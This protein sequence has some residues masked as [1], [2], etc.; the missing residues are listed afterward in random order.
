MSELAFLQD[1]CERP[2]DDAPRLIYADWLEE[3]GQ[4]GQ[5]TL[6]RLDAQIEALP[7]DDPRRRQLELDRDELRTELLGEACV[8]GE[9]PGPSW[10]ELWSR[11]RASCA[12]C[13][14]ARGGDASEYCACCGAS[15]LG[16]SL[17]G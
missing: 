17:T 5:A 1:V 6:V 7:A 9:P 10:L 14:E 13:G 16:N 12:R 8:G 15:F 2:D 3:H 11:L 4:Q